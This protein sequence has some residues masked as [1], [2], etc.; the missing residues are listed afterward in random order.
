M[1]FLGLRTLTV[2]ED[3]LQMIEQGHNVKLDLDKIPEATK[4]RW[5]YLRAGRRWRSFSLKVPDADYLRKLK[6]H[7]FISR[8]DERSL[9]T[10]A[11]GNIRILSTEKTET[12]NRI[13]PSEA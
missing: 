6:R 10:G 2:I 3:A 12:E 5:N 7:R 4:K 11:M 8:C 13:P 9:S 1:D